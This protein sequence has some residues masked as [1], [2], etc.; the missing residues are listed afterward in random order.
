MAT[1]DM[2]KM[3]IYA[4]LGVTATQASNQ[5]R[6]NKE[7][8]KA[9]IS[10]DPITK[11]QAIAIFNAVT[12]AGPRNSGGVNAIAQR[13]GISEKTAQAILNEIAAG[14]LDLSTKEGW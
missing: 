4:A 14:T 12:D 3:P 7:A 8:L 5:V 9:F 10:I 6:K 1:I 11:D 13:F 2:A